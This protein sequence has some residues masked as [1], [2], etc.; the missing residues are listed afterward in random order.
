MTTEPVNTDRMTT[1]PHPR[2]VLERI[3]LAAIAHRWLVLLL[4]VILCAFGL[5]SAT[6]LPVDAVPDITNVQ[7]QVNTEA[8]GMTPLEVEQRI[9]YPLETALAGLPKLEQT[10]SLSRYGLSQITVVFAD[11]TDIYFAR[12]LVSERLNGAAP[13]LPPGVRPKMGPIATGLGE[14]FL[15]V[16]EPAKDAQGKP[17]RQADGSA[18]TP[19]QLRTVHDWVVRPQLRT[20]PGVI[21][22]NTIGG[23]VRQVHILPELAR[24][25]ARGVTLSDISAAL[26][27]GNANVGA[28]YIERAGEQYLVRLPGLLKDFSELEQ[29]VIAAP[30]G[31]P[32]R[33]IDIAQVREGTELRTGAATMDGNEVVLGTVFMLMGANSREV[34]QAVALKLPI[35]QKSLPAGVSVH[36]VYDRT[37]LVDRTIATVR[38]NLIEG[39]VLVVAV[40]VLMLGNL[41]GA[42]IVAAVIPCAMLMTAMGMLQTRT[43]ANLMSLGALDFGL[44]VD[45]AVI[46][47]ENCLLQLGIQQRIL[48]R[49]LLRD[50]RF[51]VCAR[52]ASEVIRPSLFGVGIIT[53][54]YLPILSLSGVEGKMFVPMAA[55]VVMALS[56]SMLLCLTLVPAAAALLLSGHIAEHENRLLSF[57]KR[58]YRPCLRV[59]TRY[60]IPTIG[61]ALALILGTIVLLPRLGSEFLPS[62]EEGDLA[63]HALRIPGTSLTQAIGMQTALEARIRQFPEVKTVFSKIGTADVA[64]D[65][66][67]PSVADTFLILKARADWPNPRKSSDALVAEIAAAVQQI[68]G[69]NYEFTQPIQMRFNELIS[70]VRTDVAVKVMGDDMDVLLTQAKKVA[71]AMQTVPGAVSV[72]VEQVTG[73]PVLSI[74][75]KRAELARLGLS[76]ADVQQLVATAIGGSTVGQLIEGDRR[77]DIVIRLPEAQRSDFDALA[78]LA[79]PLPMRAGSVDADLAGAPAYI[80]LSQIADISLGTGPNQINREQGKRRVVVTANVDGRDLGSF[81]SDLKQVV[82]REVQPIPGY[83]LEYGGTFK[84]LESASKRLGI[85]VPATLLL[86]FVLLWLALGSARDAAV[87]YSGVPLALTG[88][89]LALLLRGLPFSISA[90]VGFIALSGI[91]VLN[92]LV[93]VSLMKSLL[94]EGKSIEVAVEQGALGRFRAVIVTALVAGLGFVPMALNVGAGSEV[95][96]P[97]ATVVIGGVISATL[98]TLL[99]LP[100]LY[101]LVYRAPLPVAGATP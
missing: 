23:E 4:T 95:Q 66:M 22:V 91:A 88:G 36:T 7:V 39:A 32:V 6:Q 100:A 98:L 87:V 44:I 18:W 83:W 57:L 3:I 68:A 8:A 59:S 54:V 38:N 76:N 82:A 70:G 14:I 64:T 37:G 10:R 97:L 56:A 25:A 80:P 101:R 43:S 21:E 12:Q 69:N 20:I 99:V 48:G 77:F 81:V 31:I 85:V 11:G 86:I 16:V 9:T 46:V 53:A 62:L 94:A 92:G 61:A 17:A 93:M 55:V 33:I 90:A 41:R 24:M 60:R 13:D 5:Y 65:P 35:I 28:G 75:P 84:Q 1:E 50:E 74:T 79:V 72:E 29:L 89:V 27:N 26:A 34:A 30:G 71:A 96:R 52:A 58:I 2:G 63:M 73:L 49:R 67:P 19:M 47:V 42:L 15:Y 51:A 45:G 40:L 78:R